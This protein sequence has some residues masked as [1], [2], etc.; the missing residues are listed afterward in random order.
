VKTIRAVPI[1]VLTVLLALTACRGDLGTSQPDIAGLTA[2]PSQPTAA[3]PTETPTATERQPLPVATFTPVPTSTP[4]VT[5]TPDTGARVQLFEPDDFGQDRNPLTGELVEDPSALARRPIAVKVSNAPPRTVRPQSGLSQADVVFE[6]TTEGPITRFTAI[7]YGSAPPRIGSIR[8]ARLI[9][10]HIVPMY[11][12]A[13]A[14]SGSSIG[15]SRLLFGSDFRERILRTNVPG[16]FRSGEDKPYEHTLYAEP[17]TLWTVMEERGLN[18]RPD[19]PTLVPF[20]SWAPEGGEEAREAVVVYQN[21][22]EII[23]RFDPEVGRYARWVDGA[24][25]IDA[26]NGEQLTAANIVV[27]FADHEL[28]RSVCEL[29][30]GDV[31]LAF[32]SDAKLLGEG[33]AVLLRDGQRYAATWRRAEVGQLL[34]LWN[35]SGEPLPLQIGQTW[36]QVIPTDYPDALASAP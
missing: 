35:D 24:P 11:D 23:W 22:T 29:Q 17:E 33:G 30:R 10:M 12:A 1:V 15:L 36:Y 28:D 21:F 5:P 19:L 26:N 20:D 34:T 13:L 2:A 7:V 3:P 9:D 32:G 4:P 8:S 18:R 27:I 25:H 6:H 31:C 14:Y 16:Y